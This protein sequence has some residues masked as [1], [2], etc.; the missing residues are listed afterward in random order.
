VVKIERCDGGDFARRYDTAVNGLSAYFVWANR[1]KQ[2]VTLDIAHDR[3]RCLLEELISLADV[4]VHNLAPASARRLDL[5]AEA[6]V[7]R[8]PSLVACAISGFGSGGPMSDRR[9]YDLLLQAEAGFLDITGTADQRVKAGVSIVDIAAGMYAYSSI[10]AALLARA[11][12]GKGSAIDVSMLDAM[13]EWMSMPLYYGHYGGRP[14]ERAGAAHATIAPY[15]PFATADGY[16]LLAVQHE[17]EWARLCEQVLGKAE[18]ATDDRFCSN[19]ARVSHRTELTAA[20]EHVFT[21][22]HTRDVLACLDAAGI[23]SANVSTL[24]DVWNHPQLR[25]RGRFAEIDSPAG[26]LTV[27]RP[28]AELPG[29]A[30]LGPVPE[31][32]EHTYAV[33]SKLG[34][35]SAQLDDLRAADVV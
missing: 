5:E 8:H 27:L 17:R 3:G 10:L 24:D 26:L 33:L 21:R 12:T 13:T 31:L 7:E 14:P 32:G 4:F 22:L 25:A 1:T 28:P 11:R 18:L 30:C 2:S 35:S 15:G 34:L 9:A 16:V 6:L 19:A 23:A 29:G 20:I